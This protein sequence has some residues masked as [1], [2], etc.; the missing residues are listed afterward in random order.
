MGKYGF[1]ALRRTSLIVG[2]ALASSV[3]P[4]FADDTR[5]ADEATAI[6][7]LKASAHPF[8]NV[9]PSTDDLQPLV[10][11]LGNAQVVGIGEATHGSHEDWTFKADLIEALIERGRID[12]VVLEANRQ[13]GADLDAYVVGRGGDLPM[14]LRSPSLFR[15]LRTEEFADLMTWIRAWNIQA[16]RPVRVLGIDCQDAGVDANTALAFVRAHDRRLAASFDGA[17][18]TLTAGK[19]PP[20]FAVWQNAANAADYTKATK[21]SDRLE[22]LFATHRDTWAS[23]PG[24]REAAYA[25]RLARQAF[26]AFE[27]DNGRGDPEKDAMEY[28]GRRDRSMAANLLEQLGSRRAVFS[29]HDMHVLATLPANWPTGLTWVGCELR[30]VLGERYQTV[31]FAW[32]RGA[33]RAQ[34]QTGDPAEEVAHRKPLVPQ[35]LPNDGPEDLGGVLAHTGFEHFWVDLR[36]LPEDPWAGRFGA[37]PYPR[38]WAGWRVDPTTWNRDVSDLASLRPATDI[39]VWSEH[40]TPSHMLPGDDF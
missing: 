28:Y 27:L 15:N 14:L 31:T 5:Q 11:A 38:G 7:W 8:A 29:A 26:D 4:A 25:A 22:R 34:T 1:D 32:S 10:A 9:D 16:A 24:Y 23:Q 12:V 40:I 33:F 39:L 30:R 35:T 6:Q 18:G 3:V 20:R 13:I 21:A 17:F 36:T 37:T 19:S 2:L